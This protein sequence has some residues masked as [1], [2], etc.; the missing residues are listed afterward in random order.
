MALFAC[1]RV[2]SWPSRSRRFA[3]LFEF[4]S[5]IIGGQR[6]DNGIELAIHHLVELMQRQADAMVGDAVLREVVR[7]DLLAAV[8]GADHGTPLRPYLFLLLL[9]LHLIEA[10]AEHAQRLGAILNLRFFV[11]AG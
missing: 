3:L 6:V 5:L 2:H 1:I 11:L 8:A 10:R 4:F 7:P 9:E